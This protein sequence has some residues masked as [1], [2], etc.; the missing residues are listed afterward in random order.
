MAFDILIRKKVSIEY[1][2]FPEPRSLRRSTN[3]REKLRSQDTFRPYLLGMDIGA[4][5]SKCNEIIWPY[6]NLNFSRFAT[7]SKYT[8]MNPNLRKGIENWSGG[9]LLEKVV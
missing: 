2:F 7:R 8:I 5:I 4:I 6:S 1:E 3:E 9:F